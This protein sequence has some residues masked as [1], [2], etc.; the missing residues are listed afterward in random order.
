MRVSLE[1]QL[2]FERLLL[3]LSSHFI[4]LPAEQI[5]SQIKRGLMRIC[6]FLRFDRCTLFEYSE[7]L[8]HFSATHSWTVKHFP[9]AVP[10]LTI[11]RFPWIME[12]IER[13]ETV[14]IAK[15]SDLPDEAW[16]SRDFFR[17]HGHK[18][19]VDIP[20][21]VGGKTLGIMAFA[22]LRKERFWPDEMLQRLELIGGI[23][24]NAIRRKRS[25][26][27]LQKAFC[28]IKLLKEQ[29]QKDNI[30]L[31]EEIDHAQNV[32][33]MIGVSRVFRHALCQIDQIAPT[34]TTVLIMGATGTGKELVARAI[35]NTSNRKHRPLVVVNCA[36]LSPTL[37]ESEL[38]GHEKGAFTG[39][40]Q[41]SQGRFEFAQGTSLFL[42][43]VGELPL[44][45][46]AKLLRVLQDGEFERLGSPRI[47]HT[48]ARIIAATNRNLETDVQKGR[49]RQ[50]LWY[51]LN[52]FPIVMPPLCDR[53]EDIPLLVDFF[54]KK[55]SSKYR[56]KKLSIPKTSLQALNDYP[57]PGNIR[58]LQNLIERSVIGS[59]GNTLEIMLPHQSHPAG[60]R[61]CAPLTQSERNHILKALQRT[62]WKISGSFGAAEML[63]INPST[64]RSRM[65]KL[66]HHPPNPP[67]QALITCRRH[68]TGV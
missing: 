6:E 64:L 49:F 48:D 51:R 7:K 12:K 20:L 11:S 40:Y 37:I 43:E 35:H 46:Q 29:L 44:A 42:D 24:T 60:K 45:L 36:A 53:I 15:I 68:D 39:A 14:V 56:K 62:N 3:D 10:K 52:I 63:E 58:E 26:Q 61:V 57:W 2:Q 27:S 47:H 23:F 38:F 59:K 33:K 28:E 50:D 31:R 54:I 66:G 4:N 17:R 19:V 9:P 1:K 25:D 8:Q 41:K 22:T 5:D 65:K 32:G 21:A 13:G 18:S 30:Y 16:R 34:D 55:Y 67:T